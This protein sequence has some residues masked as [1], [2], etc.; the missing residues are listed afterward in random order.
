MLL[1]SILWNS[2]IDGMNGLNQWFNNWCK[3]EPNKFLIMISIYICVFFV[4]TIGIGIVD[5]KWNLALIK[6]SEFLVFD[7]SMDS[8]I[9]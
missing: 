1:P 6:F 7:S 9:Q 8:N 3:Y 4:K 2:L 5:L